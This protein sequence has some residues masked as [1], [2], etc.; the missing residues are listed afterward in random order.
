MATRPTPPRLKLP[1]SLGGIL[2]NREAKPRL[3]CVASHVRAD[4][5]AWQGGHFV[6]PLHP[7]RPGGFRATLDPCAAG[8]GSCAA[9]AF[10]LETD[11][12]AFV[13]L[14]TQTR[15][16]PPLEPCHGADGG[17]RGGR[18]FAPT[19][20]D[21]GLCPVDPTKG[22]GPCGTLRGGCGNHT[23]RHAATTRRHGCPLDPRPGPFV[24]G[25]RRGSA[26]AQPVRD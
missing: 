4:R 17:A 26:L 11:Q 5:T 21:H 16:S 1:Q 22:R 15:A 23:R 19:N 12:R 10:C 3:S 18:G 9:K 24:P 8:T 2:E 7:S 14:G 25:A 6:P 20:P 13:P